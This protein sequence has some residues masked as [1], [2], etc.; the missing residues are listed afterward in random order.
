M[1]DLAELNRGLT[2]ST[3]QM[4]SAG[5]NKCQLEAETADR[6]Q[7]LKKERKPGG[8]KQRRVVGREG[9]SFKIEERGG[10]WDGLDE[11]KERGLGRKLGW[12]GRNG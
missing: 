8:A 9:V 5:N 4:N 11:G 6:Q 2:A 10:S 12:T 1:L 3:Y 7:R